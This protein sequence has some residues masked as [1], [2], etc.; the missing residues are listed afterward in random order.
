[1]ESILPSLSGLI[2]ALI[3]VAVTVGATVYF[4]RS[5]PGRQV[6]S[7]HGSL[8]SLRAI[9]D[10]SVY[11]VLTKEIVTTVDHSWGEFGRKYLEWVYSSRKMAIIFE[12]EIDFR[13]DLKRSD[14]QIIGAGSGMFILR[15]PPCFYEANVKSIQFYDEQRSKLLPFL[16]PDLLNGFLGAGFTE[17]DKNRLFSAARAAAEERAKSLI[18][19]I[20][21]DVEDSAR[22]TLQAI[23]RAF[24]AT[25]VAVEFQR[26]DSAR[27]TLQVDPEMK[28][29]A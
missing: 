19:S 5:R 16:L 1:M 3:L 9:G 23:A 18:K 20:S 25:T 2:A 15:M 27:M 22:L 10:L 17:D 13:Y 6:T 14:F 4:L 26:P 24:G 11:K 7:V 12:F 8:E 29:A 28:K 21:S